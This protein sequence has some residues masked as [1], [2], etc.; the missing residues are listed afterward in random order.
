MFISIVHCCKNEIIRTYIQD[1]IYT[2][3]SFSALE[4]QSPCTRT[5]Q[6]HILISFL[7]FQHRLYEAQVCVCVQTSRTFQP[8][9]N[10]HTYSL[11]HSSFVRMYVC[12]YCMHR[13]EAMM[14]I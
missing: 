7:S 11:T 1:L 3:V 4:H 13:K 8:Q 9:L 14:M 12:F 5:A 2:Y 10:T 6:T